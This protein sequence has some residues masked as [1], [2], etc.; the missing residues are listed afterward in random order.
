MAANVKISHDVPKETNFKKQRLS[1]I[2]CL[3]KWHPAEIKK[4][5]EK[6]NSFHSYIPF[7]FPQKGYKMQSVG[8]S[9][10]RS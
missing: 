9:L 7:T 4:W 1:N 3:I 8:K 2:K 10:R 5:R 6:Q